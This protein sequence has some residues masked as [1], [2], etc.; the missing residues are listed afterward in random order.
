MTADHHIKLCDADYSALEQEYRRK[1]FAGPSHDM[2]VLKCGQAWRLLDGA[3]PSRYL[4]SPVPAS[5]MRYG[6]YQ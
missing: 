4:S 1:G 2:N 3:E 6:P 5:H